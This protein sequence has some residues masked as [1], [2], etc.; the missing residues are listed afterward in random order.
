MSVLIVGAM[1]ST[2]GWMS[3]DYIWKPITQDDPEV[4]NMM[5]PTQ[6]YLSCFDR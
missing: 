6:E 4:H 2:P 5:M 3:I 1:E